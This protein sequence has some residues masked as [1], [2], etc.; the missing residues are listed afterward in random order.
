MADI[1]RLGVSGQSVVVEMTDGRLFAL[2]GVL[3]TDDLRWIPLP[4]IPES[5]EEREERE[6]RERLKAM[7]M[8]FSGE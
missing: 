1:K 7:G 4:E 8:E 5:D 2:N 3:G 6:T